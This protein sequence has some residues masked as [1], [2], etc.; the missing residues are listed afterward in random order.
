M[1]L[2]DTTIAGYYTFIL[3]HPDDSYDLRILDSTLLSYIYEPV[4]IYQN[5][6]QVVPGVWTGWDTSYPVNS[7]YSLKNDATFTI[8]PVA[9]MNIAEDPLWDYLNVQINDSL[10]SLGISWT[11]STPFSSSIFSYTTYPTVVNIIAAINEVPGFTATPRPHN[12]N[13]VYTN[14]NAAGNLPVTV[15]SGSDSKA[16][17][18]FYTRSDM[19]ANY[20]VDSTAFVIC[21]NK[22]TTFI[23]KNEFLYSTHPTLV[24]LEAG[25]SSVPD[26]NVQSLFDPSYAF[27]SL[28]DVSGMVS[29]VSPG[30]FISLPIT[31]LFDVD[32]DMHGINYLTDT[33]ALNID[34]TTGS[35]L[36]GRTYVYELQSVGDIINN[37]NNQLPSLYATG[38]GL[39]SDLAASFLL[40]SGP[41]S[42][43]VDLYRGL[44]DCT[45]AY[46]TISDRLLV[47]RQDADTT[48]I[49]YLT[50]RTD[51]L[52]LLREPQIKSHVAAEHILRNDD[53]S[54]SDLYIWANNRFN[55]RQ[56]CY[57]RLNQIQQQMASN[58]SALNVNKTLI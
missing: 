42:P 10:T 50:D 52:N 29:R 20:Y 46:Q 5:N 34:W 32:F 33:T 56:G 8:N 51:Y 19:T 4:V 6:G 58:Q 55:R 54:P 13:Y 38:Y 47:N 14:L 35:N 2:G 53:G 11:S 45:V 12:T 30:T 31:P 3:H 23:S 16:F 24:I 57:S 43:N 41:I 15:F 1:G 39:D 26:M 18:M 17:S 40:A 27:G 25:I 37:I 9:A 44:R 21:R 28:S 36:F 7:N 22:D 48:R 49:E